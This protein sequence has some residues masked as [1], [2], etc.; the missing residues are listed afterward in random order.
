MKVEDT[1]LR[2]GDSEQMIRFSVGGEDIDRLPVRDFFARF[3]AEGTRDTPIAIPIAQEYVPDP[4][5]HEF[6]DPEPRASEVWWHKESTQAVF[7][8]AVRIDEEGAKH[9]AFRSGQEPIRALPLEQFMVEYDYAPTRPPCE[10][11][12]EWIDNEDQIIVVREIRMD[13]REVV[14]VNVGTNQA[15]PIPFPIFSTKYQRLERK[16]A[17]QR[18]LEDDFEEP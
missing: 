3:A 15:R 14:A 4:E 6:Q 13:R 8:T 5:G 1:E 17:Y 9:V 7:V 10:P 16:S 2:E 12:E 11:G 18:I